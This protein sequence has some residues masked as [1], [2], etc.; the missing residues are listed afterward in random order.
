[1]GGRPLEKGLCLAPERAKFSEGNG[2]GGHSGENSISGKTGIHFKISA[3]MRQ[4]GC[5]QA[6]RTGPQSLPFSPGASRPTKAPGQG[7][8]GETSSTEARREGRCPTVRSLKGGAR[9][10]ASGAPFRPG[11]EFPSPAR[12]QAPFTLRF[13]LAGYHVKDGEGSRA[14]TL[15]QHLREA[16]EMRERAK[17]RKDSHH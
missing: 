15:V 7:L 16:T 3:Q 5:S 13:M 9:Q 14:N 1:M 6:R 11:P 17:S 8:S 10:H 4:Q 2:R 12:S